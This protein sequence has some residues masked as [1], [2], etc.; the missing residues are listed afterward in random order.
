MTPTTRPTNRPSVVA[1]R[2]FTNGTFIGFN[3]SHGIATVT[4]ERDFG[5]VTFDQLR[6]PEG[7]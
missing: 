1:D 2:A 5:N 3:T 4:P 7:L 6:D